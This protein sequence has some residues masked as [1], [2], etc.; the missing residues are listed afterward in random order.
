MK[1]LDYDDRIDDGLEE[2]E[3]SKYEEELIKEYEKHYGEVELDEEDD[4]EGENSE[5]DEY[6]DDE[7]S[8]EI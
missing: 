7:D 1:N 5:V 6:Y 2:N 8:T 3:D 4:Y